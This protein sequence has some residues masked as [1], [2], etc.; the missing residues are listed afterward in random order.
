MSVKF[1]SHT[2]LNELL[3]QL[4]ISRGRQIHFHTTLDALL[5]QFINRGREIHFP[6][7]A[8]CILVAIKSTP[9][10]R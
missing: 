10:R 2:T 6:Y 1:A 7:N 5:S 8:E 4:F 3:A 9:I